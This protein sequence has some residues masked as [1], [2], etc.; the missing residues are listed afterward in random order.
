M[1]GYSREG[2][3][4]RKLGALIPRGLRKAHSA[5]HSG[6]FKHPERRPMGTGLDLWGQRKDGSHFPVEISL[7]SVELDGGRLAVAFISDTTRRKRDEQDL[8]ESREGLRQLTNRLVTAAEDQTRMWA[9]ELHD[10]Y[11]QRLASVSMTLD[12]LSRDQPADSPLR[13][14]EADIRSLADDIHRMSRRMHPSVLHDLGLGAALRSELTS[15]QKEHGIQVDFHA[16]GI[17]ANLPGA[18]GLCLYRVAQEA[19]TN[20]R[21]HSRAQRVNVAVT[22]SGDSLTMVIR[23]EGKG[24]DLERMAHRGSLGLLSME[25]RV[26]IVG[27]DFSIESSSGRGTTVRVEIPLTKRS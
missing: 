7:S 8:L 2:L 21:K 9:R 13:G 27:G 6:F 5:Q 18:M 15:F 1:F 20:I 4:G 22:G 16:K 19:L 23:D 11:S 3:L 24:F 10:V 25:E 14:V 26:Q 12:Q 17:P